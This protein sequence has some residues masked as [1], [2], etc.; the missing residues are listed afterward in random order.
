M[1]DISLLLVNTGVWPINTQKVELNSNESDKVKS[2]ILDGIN[3]LGNRAHALIKYQNRY[4]VCEHKDQYGK[5]TDY[6]RREVKYHPYM[7]EF[8]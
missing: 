1:S 6:S 3:S 5:S 4:F 7:K 2:T 8:V